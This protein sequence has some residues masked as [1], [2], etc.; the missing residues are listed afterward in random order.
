MGLGRR[1]R[2]AILLAAAFGLCC[3]V[4]SAEPVYAGDDEDAHL[5]LFSGRDL[6]RNGAFLYGGFIVSP[7]GFEESGFLLKL[8]YSNGLYRYRAGDLDG[9]TVI[10][11]EALGH[12][13]PGFL[14]KRGDFES[15]FFFGP[16]LQKHWLWPDDPGNKLRGR[17][18]GLRMSFDIWYQPTPAS[19]IA[20]DASLSS[21]GTNFSARLGVGW[22]VLGEFYL[23]PE[24]QV[25]GG[26]GYRQFR[27]GA[28]VTSM[29]TGDTEWSA[30]AGWSFDTDRQSS[31]YVRLNLMQRISN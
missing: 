29:K 11:A 5:M 9:E 17:T 15:K 7:G 13:A 23:G 26:D 31:P 1:V 4:L 24:T 28:H 30:A 12:I 8:L 10:G 27:L 25:Y 16:E 22:H 18:L 20:A 19:M 6:W 21:I 3:V 2:A 14:L